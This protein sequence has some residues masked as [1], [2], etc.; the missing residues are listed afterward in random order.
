MSVKK[1]PASH[2]DVYSTDADVF[3][4]LISWYPN[5][6]DRTRFITGKS[7]SQHVIDIKAAFDALLPEKT[8][9]LLGFHALTS[10]DTTGKFAGKTK[11]KC[12]KIFLSCSPSILLVLRSLGREHGLPC[13]ETIEALEEYVY[14]IYSPRTRHT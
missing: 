11:G 6:C 2:L 8:K 4:L 12:F 14:R 9:S 13:Q 1:S 10:S 3:L 5:L 7:L